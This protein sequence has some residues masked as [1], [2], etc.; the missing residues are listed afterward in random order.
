MVIGEPRSTWIHYGSEN[1]LDHRVPALPSTAAEAGVPAFSVDEAVAVRPCAAFVVEQPVPPVATAHAKEVE[2]L[3]PVVSRAVT[4]TV[5][6]PAAVGVPEM[7]PEAE[8]M[9]SP[10]GRPVAL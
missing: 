5:E 10:A 3:A 8:L 6:L 9:D 1:A 4:V 2:P 7:R